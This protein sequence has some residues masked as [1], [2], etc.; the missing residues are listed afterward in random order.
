M[1]DTKAKVQGIVIDDGTQRVP[2][3]NQF[4]DEIGVFY[5]RPTDIGIL[6]RYDKMVGSFDEITKP[7]QD[8]GIAADG[9]PTDEDDDKAVEA[10]REA[11]K[12]LYEAVDKLFAGNMS[13]A[14][15]GRMNPFSP[16]GG[17]FYCELAI[18]AVGEYITKEFGRETAA[19]NKRVASYTGRYEKG[20]KN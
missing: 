20:K 9:T 18:E 8:I 16:V 19:M 14:F 17:R 4:G 6:D 2:I 15:F 3:K 10:L 11:E 1:A 13:E 12:R 7:L 5:V